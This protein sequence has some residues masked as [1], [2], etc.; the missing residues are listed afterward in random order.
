LIL[1]N[2]SQYDELVAGK[3]Q[4][5]GVVRADRRENAMFKHDPSCLEGPVSR[6]LGRWA[7]QKKVVA[8]ANCCSEN[9][10]SGAS[11]LRTAE[12]RTELVARIRR[13]I[14]QGRYDTDEKWEA[15]LQLLFQ[16][17][18]NGDCQI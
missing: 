16:H 1:P 2:R 7:G 3:T 8:P 4:R 6:T 14:A 9:S 12:I 18:Q 5:P 11:L 13:E 15:A 17:L 10:S